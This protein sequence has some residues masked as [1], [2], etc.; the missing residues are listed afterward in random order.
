MLTPW[1]CENEWRLFWATASGSIIALPVA[2]LVRKKGIVEVK[3]EDYS[4]SEADE[5]KGASEESN[6]GL[7]E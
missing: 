5:S 6:K 2:V 3:D 1:V 4:S 7:I